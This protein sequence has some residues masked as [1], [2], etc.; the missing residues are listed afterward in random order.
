VA[1]TASW[2]APWAVLIAD[3]S[4]TARA[5][6]ARSSS[7]PGSGPVV[8][9]AF[10]VAVVVTG[11]EVEG[12][13]DG[14]VDVRGG[15]DDGSALP[16]PA[17]P[18]ASAA[19]TAIP[20]IARPAP[21][22]ATSCRR[23]LPA[24]RPVTAR[25]AHAPRTTLGGTPGTGT[26]FAQPPAAVVTR[27]DAPGRAVLAKAR[28][29]RSPPAIL[30]EATP[31]QGADGERRTM[32]PRRAAARLLAPV[33]SRRRSSNPLVPGYLVVGTKRG[34]STTLAHWISQHPQVAPCR[35]RKGTHYFDVNHGRGWNWYLSAFESAD[36]PW[37]MTGEASPYYMFHP[38]APERI[39]RELPDARLVVSLRDPVARAWS[40]HK[41]E[42]EKGYESEPFERALDLETERTAGE[43]DRI[44]A[45]HG[46]E[47]FAHRHHTYLAR[48]LYADQ[49]ERLHQH[50]DPSRVLV[51]S[52][53]AM[54][55]DPSGQLDRVWDHLGLDRVRIDGTERFKQTREED[56]P[57]Q[58]RARL[59]DYYREPNDRLYAMPGIDFRWDG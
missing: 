45:D 20:T 52:S 54:F 40:H 43:E 49:L 59:V 19:T 39:A 9:V 26:A 14:D 29:L 35:T 33:R 4:R 12:V 56:V 3:R 2:R 15:E 5:A 24:P 38:L 44:R 51:L 27:P 47:S 10:A 16:Q 37:T 48:G 13:A 21:T 36:G 1:V 8:G 28:T 50:V 7:K 11:A 41:Y 30:D 46:Y 42:T 23:G 18:P 55:A 31:D 17:S 57:Q 53:E 6:S 58:A 32:D 34:G 25:G 22:D